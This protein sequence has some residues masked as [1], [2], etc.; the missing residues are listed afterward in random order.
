MSKFLNG[1]QDPFLLKLAS[2]AEHG[3]LSLTIALGL[4]LGLFDYI[5][6]HASKSKPIT[7]EQ[8]GQ[9]LDLKPR[10]IQ[11][12]LNTMATSE[13]MEVDE[14]GQK[15][16]IDP[17]HKNYISGDLKHHLFVFNQ[18]LPSFGE[19]FNELLEVCKKDGPCGT[20]YSSY[21]N[22]HEIMGSVSRSWHKDH[23]IKDYIPLIEQVDALKRG[24]KVL[25]VGCGC[26]FH[27]FELATA[28]PKSHFTGLDIDELTIKKAQAEK[29]ARHIKNVELVARD[30][31]KM[32]DEWKDSFDLVLIFDAC[33]DQTRPDL[34]LKEIQRVLKPD[35]L[36]AMCEYDGTSNCY[37]DR[38]EKAHATMLYS[39]SLFH[40]L[41]IGSNSPDALCLGNMWGVER[42]K[43]LLNGAGFSNITTKEI[44]FF[45][46][47]VLYLARK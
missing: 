29:D 47:N 6:E 11:E 3:M 30:A 8:I 21:G 26:G 36:F 16:W 46:V 18:F 25:D 17:A 14:T 41:P 9:K 7:A 35:G 20:D 1:S 34:S 33:H 5:G 23:M 28:F 15:F 44:P 37:K 27:V 10:Y 42:G 40:C 24:I 43:K 4:K 32:P 19:M 45:P 22:F 38:T 2:I 12:F 13:L 31:R 39:A